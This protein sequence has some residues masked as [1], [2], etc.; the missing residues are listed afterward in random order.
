PPQFRRMTPLLSPAQCTTLA[1]VRRE[2]DRLDRDIVRLLAERGRYVLGAARVKR[3]DAEVQAPERD[4]QVVAN[5]L[6]LAADD[7]AIPDVVERGY[8]A[9]IAAYTDAERAHRAQRP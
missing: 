5:V 2:I 9:L 3:N 8:R 7:G 4:E 1:D 6:R